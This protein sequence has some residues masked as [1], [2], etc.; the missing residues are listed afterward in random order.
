MAA[1]AKIRRILIVDDHPLIRVG[2][3]SLIEAEADLE[4]FG[5]TGKLFVE[6]S[7]LE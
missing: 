7:M 6:S 3:S 2:L 5:E 1:S 4:V